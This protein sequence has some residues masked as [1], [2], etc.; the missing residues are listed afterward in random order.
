MCRTKTELVNYKKVMLHLQRSFEQAESDLAV[1]GAILFSG[2]GD[3]SLNAGHSNGVDKAFRRRQV[4]LSQELDTLRGMLHVIRSVRASTSSICKTS[5]FP[6]PN[7][8]TSARM[9]IA[10][11]LRRAAAAQSCSN[12]HTLLQMPPYTGCTLIWMLKAACASVCVTCRAG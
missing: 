1:F 8:S 3:G 6:P 11:G 2:D 5:R 12:G 4:K 7:A 10:S 9:F